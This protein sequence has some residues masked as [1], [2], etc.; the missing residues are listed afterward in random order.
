MKVEI[1]DAIQENEQAIVDL[2]DS[3]IDVSGELSD[4]IDSESDAIDAIGL[5]VDNLESTVSGHTT[6]ISELQEDVEGIQSD[7]S[8]LQ[9]KDTQ[10][11]R[12]IGNL[13]DSI[14][15]LDGR[16]TNDEDDIAAIAEVIPQDATSANKLV[17]ESRLAQAIADFGGF[18]VVSLD[19]N[20]EEPDVQTPSEKIIYLTKDSQSTATDPYT[21]WIYRESEWQ[22]IG[23]T[24]VDLSNYYTKTETDDLLD[25]KVD[26]EDGKGLSTNDFT[27][28]YQTKLDEIETSAQKN[29]QSDWEE[30][31]V[32]SDAFIK[33][34]PQSLS[35][36]GGEGIAVEE[37]PGQ[38][39]I[40]V[41]GSYAETSAVDAA[42]ALK[43][44][45][46]MSAEFYPMDTN[47]S[48]Y[49]TSADLS[50][51]ATE[52]YVDNALDNKMDVVPVPGTGTFS[53]SVEGPSG[54]PYWSEWE[55]YVPP[56]DP[57]QQVIITQDVNG[58]TLTIAP[59]TEPAT[60]D[61]Y[62]VNVYEE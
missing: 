46:S 39:E 52:D 12:D 32:N 26:K 58:D 11:E 56:A 37:T 25:D 45:K 9:E 47:P 61:H 42:L 17:S 53:L 16:L 2:N 20:T 15:E 34:K 54:T 55:E 24:T 31:D 8:D 27:D 7:I 62:E 6:S 21:E 51:Y 19:P 1:Y 29:V 4:R 23:D 60:L 3:L 10:I 33:N 14:E 35:I 22:I 30:S 44:D 41:S 43:M 36:V 59:S 50:E 28:A 48:G 18:E 40:S 57:I 49:L 5:E 13:S 38:L